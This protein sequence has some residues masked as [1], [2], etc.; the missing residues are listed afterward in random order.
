VH[1]PKC[2]GTQPAPFKAIII[3]ISVVASQRC[4]YNNRMEED[5]AH[6][7][8]PFVGAFRT[9]NRPKFLRRTFQGRL[10]LRISDDFRPH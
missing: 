9:H 1:Y 4:T 6:T 5:L 8:C 10:N 7:K 2:S 3:S